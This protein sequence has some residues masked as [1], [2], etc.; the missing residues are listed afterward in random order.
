MNV[1]H[2]IWAE[3]EQ[4]ISPRLPSGGAANSLLSGTSGA[5]CKVCRETLKNPNSLIM[6]LDRQHN[7]KSVPYALKSYG[8]V[9]G[10][11]EGE[12]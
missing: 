9:G 10:D 7:L 4:S 8:M 2:P 1:S 11:C 5:E 12:K 6:H 3:H